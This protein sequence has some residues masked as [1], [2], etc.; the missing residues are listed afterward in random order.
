MR[1][2]IM[3]GLATTALLAGLPA[4]GSASAATA[5]EAGATGVTAVRS[6]PPEQT[7]DDIQCTMAYNGSSWYKGDWVAVHR[8]RDGNS[9]VNGYSN[10]SGV[11]RVTLRNGRGNYVAS[12]WVGGNAGNG[13]S[14]GAVATVPTL[15]GAIEINGG[16][17]RLTV[18]G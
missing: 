5:S 18:N 9:W 16:A 6:C 2:K 17:S 10:K 13:A 15:S 8:G 14:A 11:F 3:L 4:A 1:T 7:Y 12:G